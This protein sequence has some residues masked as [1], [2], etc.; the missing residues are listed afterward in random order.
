MRARRV[1]LL[2][3]GVVAVFALAA[4]S[5]EA[6]TPSPEN[7]DEH[8]PKIATTPGDDADDV[9]PVKPV[10]VKVSGGELDS[11]SMTNEAGKDLPGELAEDKTSWR[12][13]EPLGY[14]KEYTLKA[15]ASGKGGKATSESTFTTL[16][17]DQTVFP[18]FYP[19]PGKPATVGVGQPIA[20]IFDKPPADR[21]AAEKALKVTTTPQTEGG[22][23][24]WDDRT[25]H[26]RP[27]N[28]WKAGTKVKVDAN[29]Y[30]VDL[31]GGMYGETDRT[32]NLT[33]GP[34]KVATIDDRT[35]RMV[36]TVNGK[37]VKTFP[38]SMGRGGTIKGTGGK[39]ISLVTPSGTYV[40]QE[41]YKVKRMTSSS[42]G[43]PSNA[44]LGYDEKIPLAVRISNSGIFVHSAPWS[45]ADQGHR[46]VSHGCVNLS[47]SAGL[48]FYQN[49]GYGD[50]V[51]IKN[52]SKHHEPTDGFGDW[53]I[54]WDK[55]LEGSALN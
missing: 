32:L 22:W 19:P 10:E 31:G 44:S 26:Y 49:F 21:K 53:N 6:G 9:S 15:T 8:G 40:A 13:S 17:P 45:V 48:W 42:Y 39:K 43:L 47:P 37:Q 35:H 27:H 34:A 2:V 54:P 24:W 38:V 36:V 41:K 14:A 16:K 7:P 55:W 25:L 30:G 18:S 28:Y 46:N 33:I 1:S 50:I 12:S 23:F 29:I 52:T 20:V 4:C 51:T 11:V 3:S 5:T